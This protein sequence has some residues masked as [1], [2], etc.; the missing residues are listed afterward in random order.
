MEKQ[1]RFVVA[2]AVVLMVVASVGV[3]LSQAQRRCPAG[4]TTFAGV[5][6]REAMLAPVKRRCPEGLV[7]VT[8]ICP[9]VSASGHDVFR[10][11]A[12]EVELARSGVLRP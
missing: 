2:V 4:E 10:M 6:T 3:A 7:G 1:T 12:E 11:T 5:L 8:L 9:H